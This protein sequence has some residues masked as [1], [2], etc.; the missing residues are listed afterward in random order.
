MLA[1]LL[2][3]MD[4]PWAGVPDG[5]SYE[6][7]DGAVPALYRADAD[8]SVVQRDKPIEPA[9]VMLARKAALAQAVAERAKTEAAPLALAA[10]KPAAPRQMYTRCHMFVHSCA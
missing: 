6:D 7:R 8:S 4:V 2:R 3:E 9:A 1:W 10:P 5:W